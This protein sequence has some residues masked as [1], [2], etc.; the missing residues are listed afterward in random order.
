MICSP[1]RSVRSRR[2]ER[3]RQSRRSLSRGQVTPWAVSRVR[4]SEPRRSRPCRAMWRSS[5]TA[6]AAGR[7]PAVCRAARAIVA[8]SRRCAGP[9]ASR[10]RRG[11]PLSDRLQLLVG[12]LVAS[13][14]RD[15]GPDEAPAHLHPRRPCR[16][17]TATASASGSSAS[18]T[19][20]RR[21]SR[22]CSTTPKR[23]TRGK[24]GLQL[25]VAFNYGGRDEIVRAARKLAARAAAGEIEPRGDRLRRARRRR[26]TRPAFPIPT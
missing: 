9:C 6:T 8:A 22:A 1:P 14:A 5:W 19:V 24:P 2:C 18:A 7:A 3:A 25:I 13:A 21:T 16:A 12:E 15:P 20:C 4:S 23:A 10:V 11:I 17:A 26:S